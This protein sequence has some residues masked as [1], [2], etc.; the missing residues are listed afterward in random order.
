MQNKDVNKSEGI[1]WKNP[2]DAAESNGEPVTIHNAGL[3][4]ASTY[5]PMLFQRLNLTDG[6]KFVDNSAQCQALFCLQWMTNH[7][8]SAPEYQL[9]LNKVLCGVPPASAIPQQIA[10]PEGAVALIDGLLTAI[11]AHWR[12]LGNTSISALQSTFIQREGQLIENPEHWQLNII[13]GTFD[14]LLD[15]LPWSFQTI[16]YPWMEKPLFVTW[17]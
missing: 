16:K 6:R 9:L 14:M 7:T 8:A 17:R 1:L 3:V 13:P 15:R 10:L 12:V 5:I 2:Q 11:I 4:I